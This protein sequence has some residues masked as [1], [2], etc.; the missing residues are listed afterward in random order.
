[1]IPVVI[2]HLGNQD[3]LHATIRVNKRVVPSI[4]L[5]GDSSNVGADAIHVDYNTLQTP[6]LEEFR[7]HFINYQILGINLEI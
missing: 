7:K 2:F 5:I 3:Y 1:M 6:E 4:T